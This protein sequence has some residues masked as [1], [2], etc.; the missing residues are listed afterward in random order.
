MLQS[1]KEYVCFSTFMR[2]QI[3]LAIWNSGAET[4]WNIFLTFHATSMLIALISTDLHPF[5]CKNYFQMV[6]CILVE[7]ENDVFLG[8]LVFGYWGFGYWLLDFWLLGFGYCFFS[9]WKSPWPSY[10]VHIFYFYSMDGFFRILKK[11]LSK[12]IWSQDH[13]P[14]IIP[15]SKNPGIGISRKSRE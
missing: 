13:E 6:N 11:G 2:L 14:S 15:G 3:Q 12:L 10:E 4:N 7:L 9:Q 1:V 5:N 8:F